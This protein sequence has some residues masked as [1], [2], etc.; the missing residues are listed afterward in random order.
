M[1]EDVITQ[2]KIVL[3]EVKKNLKAGCFQDSKKCYEIFGAD[4]MLTENLELKL[5]EI[6]SKIGLK[7]FKK[8][9]M[10]FNNI[11]FESELQKTVDYYFPPK[12]K[13]L[14]NQNFVEII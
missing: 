4:F 14:D 7:E 6:N 11:L 10:R 1:S 8:D 13:I 12:Y 9:T 2:L 3:K 5:I